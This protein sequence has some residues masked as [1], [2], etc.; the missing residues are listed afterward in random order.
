VGGGRRAT[1]FDEHSD[2]PE[3]GTLL[4]SNARGTETH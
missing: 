2:S 1:V 3:R 4:K